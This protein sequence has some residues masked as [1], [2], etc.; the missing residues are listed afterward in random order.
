MA[1]EAS[2]CQLDMI[3]IY[4]TT[5]DSAQL[6]KQ[7]QTWTLQVRMLDLFVMFHDSARHNA[8]AGVRLY[9]SA[10]ELQAGKHPASKEDSR[11]ANHWVVDDAIGIVFHE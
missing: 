11:A 3:A 8:V 4:V 2:S 5:K 7:I 1:S 9:Q 6:A 10:R